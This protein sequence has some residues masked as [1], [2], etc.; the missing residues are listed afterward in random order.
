M[1]YDTGQ[2][3]LERILEL[4]ALQIRLLEENRVEELLKCQEQREVLF[5]SLGSPENYR[6][7]RI[8]ALADKI[9][10]NDRVLSLN[11]GMLLGDL[12]GRL[13]RIDRGAKAI[14]AYRAG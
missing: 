2:V 1:G 5:S 7:Q 13:E 14:K 3:I 11:I 4:S 6:G 9:L 12:K 8:K 10:E